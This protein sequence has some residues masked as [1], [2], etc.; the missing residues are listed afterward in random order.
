[1]FYS[2][3][4]DD[5]IVLHSWLLCQKAH[6]LLDVKLDVDDKRRQ[7]ANVYIYI[8]RI[9]NFEIVRDDSLEFGWQWPLMPSINMLWLWCT[10]IQEERAEQRCEFQIALG[11]TP[12]STW[13]TF[14]LRSCCRCFLLLLL[15][16]ISLDVGTYTLLC[17]FRAE[18]KWCMSSELIDAHVFTFTNSC[19]RAIPTASFCYNTHTILIRVSERSPQSVCLIRRPNLWIRKLNQ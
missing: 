11:I 18:W 8:K 12:L 19:I 7:Y 6:R 9:Q 13:W 1:M 3:W 2:T 4:R 10:D 5:A 15:L 14:R 16:F 17:T